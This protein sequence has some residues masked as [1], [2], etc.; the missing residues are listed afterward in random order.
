MYMSLQRNFCLLKEVWYLCNQSYLYGHIMSVGLE[1]TYLKY[2]IQI[3]VALDFFEIKCSVQGNKIGF[4][5]LSLISL[6]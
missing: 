5:V 1:S 2:L 3:T 4:D 6:S